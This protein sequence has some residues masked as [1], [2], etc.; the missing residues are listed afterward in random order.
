MALEAIKRYSIDTQGMSL[1]QPSAIFAS[2]ERRFK[3][4]STAPGVKVTPDL[5]GA[6]IPLMVTKKPNPG[7]GQYNI[8]DNKDQ[9]WV[10][11]VN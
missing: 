5:E 1:V 4:D 10:K 8:A 11:R 9:Q 3:T 7:V 6:N 2:K